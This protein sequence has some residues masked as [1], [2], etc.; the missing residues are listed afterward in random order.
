MIKRLESSWHIFPHRIPSTCFLFQ[1]LKYYVSILSLFRMFRFVQE[2]GAADEK[3]IP[4]RLHKSRNDGGIN[5]GDSIVQLYSLS[6]FFLLLVTHH[7]SMV[8]TEMIILLLGGNCK[9]KITINQDSVLSWPKYGLRMRAQ[10]WMYWTI[11]EH[12]LTQYKF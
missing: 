11:H 7:H 1:F 9:I 4:P 10:F 6:V 5:G 3:H 2:C 12:L 8:L